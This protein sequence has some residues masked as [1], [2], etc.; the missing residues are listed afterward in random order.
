MVILA[1]SAVLALGGVGLFLAG[2][3]V[4]KWFGQRP[5][6]SDQLHALRQAT[7]LQILFD[8]SR[9]RLT[10][11]SARFVAYTVSVRNSGD[12]VISGIVARVVDVAPPEDL[13]EDRGRQLTAGLTGRYL[14][15]RRD[16][17]PSGDYSL[18][19]GSEN[20]FHVVSRQVRDDVVEIVFRWTD[21]SVNIKTGKKRALMTG[22]RPLPN[23][24]YQITVRV[25]G[26]WMLPTDRTFRLT[27]DGANATMVAE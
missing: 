6:T 3:A 11:E 10:D 7:A 4:Q 14:V 26:E 20:E 15:P 19:P 1:S 25:E 18:D 2:A 17:W 21:V 12:R 27:V 13:G 5:A 24:E 8:P 22:S 16:T 9:H 23:G